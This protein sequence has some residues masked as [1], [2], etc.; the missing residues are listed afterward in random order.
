MAP[1]PE[2]ALG[3]EPHCVGIAERAPWWGGDLQT[4]RNH[5]IWRRQPL[6]SHASVLEFPTSDGS[7]DRLTGTLERPIKPA[8][9]PLVILIHG[10]TGCEDSFYVRDSAR[11][12]LAR[13]RSVLRLNLRGAGT[14]RRVAGGY[15]HAG[16]ASDL[17]D[18]IGALGHED[19]RHGV[20]AIGYSL[21]GNIL[22]NLLS[23]LRPPH[24]LLGAATVSAPIEPLEA[25]ERIMAPRNLVYHSL[26]LR[27]MKRDVL[28][29]QANF[30]ARERGLIQ[31]ARSVFEFDDKFVAPRHGFGTARK[32]YEQTAGARKVGAITVPT[33]M[34]HACND[35][36]IPASPYRA[37]QGQGLPDVEIVLTRS[38][39][40]V[41]FHERGFADAWHDRRMDDFLQRLVHKTG[42]GIDPARY[43]VTP[44]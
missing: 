16:C 36:W 33:L 12:H 20:F 14:S 10:L 13:G 23:R 41:G 1:K 15:Y 8:K 37:L 17:L 32:Y 44:G 35:P 26:L 29:P 2:E 28:S 6:E 43:G 30:T 24:P 11:F 19:T 34:L 27:R 40:H 18:V 38:G 21:G 25:C 42:L 22:L 39:G 9:S 5:L 31:D 7:G 4:I 3:V